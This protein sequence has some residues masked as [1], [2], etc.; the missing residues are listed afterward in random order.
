MISH[1]APGV[2]TNYGE[3]LR[4]VCRPDHWAASEYAT[5]MP[6]PNTPPN[7]PPMPGHSRSVVA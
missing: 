4:K 5:E 2:L 7:K 6:G 3:A 1:F